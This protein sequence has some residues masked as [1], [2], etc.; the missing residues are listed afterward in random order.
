[1][2]YLLGDEWHRMV[3]RELRQI[4]EYLDAVALEIAEAIAHDAMTNHAGVWPQTLRAKEQIEILRK[5][6]AALESR[7]YKSS[8]IAMLG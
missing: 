7:R 5:T 4:E 1:M 6:L 8:S 2:Y 3:D